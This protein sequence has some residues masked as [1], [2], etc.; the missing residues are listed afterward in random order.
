MTTKKLFHRSYKLISALTGAS[1][2]FVSSQGYAQAS[3][4]A[5]QENAP[6]AVEIDI[7][8]LEQLEP[9]T[10]SPHSRV[11]TKPVQRPDGSGSGSASAISR[12]TQNIV[13]LSANAPAVNTPF[14]VRRDSNSPAIVS[15][16]TNDKSQKVLDAPAQRPQLTGSEYVNTSKSAG[17]T[18]TIPNNQISQP[19]IEKNYKQKPIKQATKTDKTDK[20]I[21]KATKADNKQQEK[22]SNVTK[23]AKSEQFPP[24]PGRKPRENSQFSQ[25][26]NSK[27]RN[28]GVSPVTETK[29]A[30]ARA[31]IKTDVIGLPNNKTDATAAPAYKSTGGNVV[32]N[33]PKTMPAVP[34]RAV[35]AEPL[36]PPPGITQADPNDT[37]FASLKDV[38]RQKFIETV[39][40]I[41][42]EIEG[43]K[44]SAKSASVATANAAIDDITA[45]NSQI[46][47]VHSS[48]ITGKNN[49]EIGTIDPAT[50]PENLVAGLIS[51]NNGTV[52]KIEPTNTAKGLASKE[53]EP[54]VTAANLEP[55]A[56]A[57]NKLASAKINHESF[58]HVPRAPSVDQQGESAYISVP[59]MPGDESA[60]PEILGKIDAEVLPILAKNPNWRIQIQAFS[61]PDNEV[62]SSARRMAL[63]RALSVREY[64]IQKGIEAPRLDVRALGME[65]DR[66]PLDRIDFVF[67]DPNVS[68]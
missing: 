13:P 44:P 5:K 58:N 54:T 52:G 29:L 55:A 9:S 34:T 40:K 48:T 4:K 11:F 12:S 65:T 30:T 37:L 8:V 59:F 23:T 51:T 20:N 26:S 16:Q 22:Q 1:L 6:P 3:Y 28:S 10:P 56:G 36:A 25:N 61:S 21:K 60:T 35:G 64:L 7:S 2:I 62:R 39:E 47:R 68:G 27:S 53:T 31:P 14:A 57:S 33:A 45:R 41:S 42:H 38:E 24:V 43:K 17:V 32:K 50:L 18:N 63:S 15:Q 46:V 66:N 19:I 49:A 67:F